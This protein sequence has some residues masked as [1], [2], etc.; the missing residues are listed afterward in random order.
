M[1]MAMVIVSG[2]SGK[3]ESWIVVN[4]RNLQHKKCKMRAEQQD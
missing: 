3:N 4:R 2:L 1:K